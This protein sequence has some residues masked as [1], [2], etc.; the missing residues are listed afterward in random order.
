MTRPLLDGRFAPSTELLGFVEAPFDRCVPA[1]RTLVAELLAIEP[2][3]IGQQS[4]DG[5]LEEALAALTAEGSAARCLLVPTVG[6]S[7]TAVFF[8]DPVAIDPRSV[9]GDLPEALGCRTVLAYARPGRSDGPDGSST[10]G[11]SLAE[12]GRAGLLDAVRVLVVERRG[13]APVV[14]TYGDP[15]PAEP[16]D[17]ARLTL[18]SLD[19][20]LR[21][22]GIDAFAAAAYLPPGTHAVLLDAD[23]TT[24]TTL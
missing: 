5:S 1:V 24:T 2:A 6:A 22:L 21:S 7:W 11:L 10:V 4:L 15:L 12:P 3:A 17:P 18:D 13:G 19:R 9:A 23:T 16:D 20:L 8:A 14:Q